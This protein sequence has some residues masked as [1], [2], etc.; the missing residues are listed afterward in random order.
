MAKL[1]H[2]RT[3]R[4]ESAVKASPQV[5]DHF[6]NGLQALAKGHRSCLSELTS[7]CL[8]SV[9]IDEAVRSRYPSDSR[10]DYVVGVGLTSGELAVFIEVHSA[11][12]S[13]VSVVIRKKEWLEK[14]W[15]EHSDQLEL[16]KLPRR[17]FWVPSGRYDVPPNSPQSKR[18]VLNGLKPVKAITEGLLAQRILG[19]R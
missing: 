10:W 11:T 8:G 4:F 5:R 19:P 9:E 12:T 15:L 1:N 7:A 16:K 14:T 2:V 13:E 3:N 17:I 6:R 18:M